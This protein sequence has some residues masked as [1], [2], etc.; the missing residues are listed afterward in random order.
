MTV[1]QKT[2]RKLELLAY[3]Y[4]MKLAPF[5]SPPCS[6]EKD[7]ELEVGKKVEDPIIAC[8]LCG[9]HAL[10]CETGTIVFVFSEDFVSCMALSNRN[11]RESLKGY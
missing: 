1:S 2:R 10:E 7:D 3:E 9:K 5:P 11:G 8:Q 4:E 6:T